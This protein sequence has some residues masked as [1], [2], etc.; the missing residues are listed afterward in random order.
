[1]LLLRL[2]RLRQQT[3]HVRSRAVGRQAPRH[4]PTR[5]Q[6][7]L[8]LLLLLLLLRLLRQLPVQ[9]LLQRA[10][11]VLQ[12]PHADQQ[13]RAVPARLVRARQRRRGRLRVRGGA[14]RVRSVQRRRGRLR[15]LRLLRAAHP[16]RRRQFEPP[17]RLFPPPPA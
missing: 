2:A 1:V 3:A 8:L 11:R 14:L 16:R 12:P 10:A 15:A 4:R 5:A 17:Q 13:L 6:P 9:L 7:P